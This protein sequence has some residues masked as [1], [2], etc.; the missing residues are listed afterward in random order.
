MIALIVFRTIPC[1][2]GGIPLA[3]VL[4]E[5]LLP[6]CHHQN[7]ANQYNVKVSF[8]K[9]RTGKFYTGTRETGPHGV[10]SIASAVWEQVSNGAWAAP[11]STL[12]LRNAARLQEQGLAPEPDPEP[13]TSIAHDF[14]ATPEA[15]TRVV[16]EPVTSNG[17]IVRWQR[18]R[19]CHRY[20]GGSDPTPGASGSGDM[21]DSGLQT[22]PDTEPDCMP[23]VPQPRKQVPLVSSAED[24]AAMGGW[25]GFSMPFASECNR[26]L[27]NQSVR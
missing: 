21:R 12:E 7:I 15:D 20:V 1:G 23:P 2:R 22:E 16:W 8:R 9:R 3:P 10:L 13:A 25:P 24:A 19:W 18:L 5:V 6:E 4:R 11:D 14:S 26:A 17:V 27:G